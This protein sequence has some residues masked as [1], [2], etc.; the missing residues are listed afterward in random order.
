MI[1]VRKYKV[2]EVIVNPDTGEK[3]KF[4]F[5]PVKELSNEN[6]SL[7]DN[8]CPYKLKLCTR[9]PHPD[10]DYAKDGDTFRDFCDK[11]DD[12]INREEGNRPGAQ[13]INPSDYKF[14]GFVPVKGTIEENYRDTDYFQEMIKKNSL[15]SIRS[16]INAICG[17]ECSS[18]KEDLSNCKS[19][20]K[21]CILH[22]LFKAIDSGDGENK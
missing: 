13:S 4:L 20:N 1:D 6:E 19:T 14:C 12:I 21:S 15:V 9:L 7:C 18:Y 22:E 8:V 3:R 11:A 17:E 2:I 5:R 10:P 16:V